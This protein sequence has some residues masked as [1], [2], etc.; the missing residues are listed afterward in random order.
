M[1][2]GRCVVMLLALYFLSN[3][4]LPVIIDTTITT[5]IITAASGSV[6]HIKI[7]NVDYRTATLITISGV[8]L[9][10]ITFQ[11]LVEQL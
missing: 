2:T 8:L 3:Y 6:A 5:I 1:G 11:Y 4:N 7:R 10:S 9:G